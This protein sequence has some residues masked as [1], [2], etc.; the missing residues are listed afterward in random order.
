M[1]RHSITTRANMS[2]SQQERWKR[3]G[4]RE[5]MMKRTKNII[6]LIKQVTPISLTTTCDILQQHHNLL[7]EDQER[8]S[9]NFIKNI[10][11]NKEDLCPEIN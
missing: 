9:T 1:T 11:N 2:R 4:E 10:I 6:P 8:L 3:P 5:K 7:Q